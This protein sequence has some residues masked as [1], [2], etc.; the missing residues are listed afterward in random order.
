MG[1][2]NAGDSLSFAYRITNFS[3]QGQTPTV[4]QS[5]TKIEVQISTDCGETYQTVNIINSFTHSP[6]V[7]LRTRKISLDAFAGQAIKV[8]FQGTWGA[9]DFF[10]DLDNINLLSCPADMDLSAEVT[11]N[12]PGLFDGIATVEVGLGNPPYSYAWSSG[13][14]GKT[15][16]NLNA[17]TYTV[18]VSDAFGC[19]DE[20]TIILG[21]SAVDELDGF[22]KIA[23]F[24]NPTSGIT[25]L[26]ATFTHAVE[27]Q[28]EILNQLG[29]RVWY[30]SAGSTD[31]LLESVDLG[32][33]PDG[34]YLVRL[35]AEGRTITRKL[36]KG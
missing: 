17:G 2:I 3:S 24:P 4:L 23:L 34:L 33:F 10:F 18:T 11:P 36:V 8:R 14:T 35:S 20:L 32:S 6:T 29:Q 25:S 5:G 19:S 21:S 28:I 1:P 31:L 30:I 16:T 7:Q 26:Q 13:N 27:P 9:S 12:T 15:A 22:V